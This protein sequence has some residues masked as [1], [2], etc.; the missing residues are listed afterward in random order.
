MNNDDNECY[1][2]IWSFK[3]MD[4]ILCCIVILAIVLGSWHGIKR[5]QAQSFNPQPYTTTNTAEAQ[6]IVAKTN[7]TNVLWMP[8]SVNAS[9]LSFNP[10][11]DGPWVQLGLR[12]D[13]VVVWRKKP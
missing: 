6:W 8:S 9:T 1:A 10:D 7:T 11:N 4:G 2:Q 5:A 3:L 12:N 13:G